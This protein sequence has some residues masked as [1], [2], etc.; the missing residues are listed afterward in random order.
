MRI[1]K[2]EREMYP[3]VCTWFKTFLSSR[4]KNSSINV[5]DL[6]KISL[7]KFLATHESNDL[8]GEWVTWDIKVDIVGIIQQPNHPTSL[9]FV[10]CKIIPLT[11][12]HLSQLLGYS[13]ITL[14]V[15]SFLI[16]PLGMSSSLISLLKEYQRLDV[17]EYYWEK[18]RTARRVIVAKWDS[19][20]C[21]ITKIC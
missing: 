6:S 2:Q 18:G 19:M 1:Y 15:F 10:E 9:A 7:S 4:F 16:S 12:A 3:D 17:L 11:L 13:R 21:N 5:Y 14:P 8:P 20:S